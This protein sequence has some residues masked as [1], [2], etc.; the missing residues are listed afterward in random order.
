M[1]QKRKQ[2]K[3]SQKDS[4]KNYKTKE[5]KSR[6]KKRR[7]FFHVRLNK[8][9]KMKDIGKVKGKKGKLRRRAVKNEASERKWESGT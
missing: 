1:K 7:Q 5:K 3:K 8:R 6:K 4:S 2:R 9:E